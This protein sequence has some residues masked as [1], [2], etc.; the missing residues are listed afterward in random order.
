[1]ELQEATLR[2]RLL[3]CRRR[4]NQTPAEHGTEGP[5]DPSTSTPQFQGS[6]EAAEFLEGGDDSTLSRDRRRKHTRSSS[7]LASARRPMPLADCG[8]GGSGLPLGLEERLELVLAQK[9]RAQTHLHSRRHQWSTEDAYI[10]YRTL[11]TNRRRAKT[12]AAPVFPS[13]ETLERYKKSYWSRV[14]EKRQD[15]LVSEQSIREM[16]IEEAQLRQMLLECRSKGGETPTEPSTGGHSGVSTSTTQSQGIQTSG[17]QDPEDLSAKGESTDLPG[18][19]SP[20]P[21]CSWWSGSSPPSSLR[22][23]TK[24]AEPSPSAEDRVTMLQRDLELLRARKTNLVA[25]RRSIRD[26]WK[27][28]FVYVNVRLR[29]LNRRRKEKNVSYVEQLSTYGAMELPW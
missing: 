28:E 18:E 2:A 19:D 22:S 9:R 4:C 14:D 29:S 7:R 12:G 11:A 21:G 8:G 3:E 6:A 24:G 13:P 1:M 5:P 15:M 26:K 17:L 10:K 16:E 25:M 23:T 27:D 20:R